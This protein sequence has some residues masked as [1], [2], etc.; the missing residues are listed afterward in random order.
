VREEVPGDSGKTKYP[1]E[2]DHLSKELE[3]I[4]NEI[5]KAIDRAARHR[6]GR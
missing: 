4:G 5:D 2:A 6:C 3:S 1:D